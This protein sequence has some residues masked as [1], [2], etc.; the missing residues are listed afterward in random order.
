MLV[1]C[2]L[3]NGKKKNIG[4]GGIEKDC[5]RCL[6]VGYISMKEALRTEDKQ[7]RIRRSKD[8]IQADKK[9]KQRELTDVGE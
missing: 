2:D 9:F 3:C 5:S 7:K 1:K 6:G 4:L 8:Q